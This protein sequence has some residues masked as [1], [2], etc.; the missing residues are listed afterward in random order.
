MRVLIVGGGGR[1]H[2]LAWKISQSDSLSA[3]YA[4]PGNGGIAQLAKCVDIDAEDIDGLVGFAE[5]EKIDFC[6]VGPEAPLF[7]GL[8][9]RL[10][11]EGIAAFGPKQAA[12]A[13]EGSKIFAKDF[14]SRH[15]IPTAPFETFDNR[16]DALAHLAEREAAGRF[17]AVVKADG[18]ALGKGAVVCKTFSDA[19]HAVQD[20]MVARVFGPAGERIVIE[21]C[22]VGR[23]VS[24]IAFVDGK[25]IR[26]MVPAQDHKRAF[27]GD[28]GP[29]TGGMGA[30][31]P[32]P[33]FAPELLDAAKR[34]VLQ[35]TVDGLV[36]DGIEYK[37]ILYAGLM[38]TGDG[39]F[40]LE[41][42]CRFGDPETQ[43]VLPLMSGDLLETMLLCADGRLDR[44]QI[45]WREEKALCVVLASGGY[46]G[47]YDKGFPIE[48]LDAVGDPRVHVFHAG[49]AER[50]GRIVSNGGRVL[51]VTG[52]DVSFEGALRRTYAAVNEIR[53]AKR[54]FRRD[55]GTDAIA[56]L[57]DTG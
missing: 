28:G 21:D 19:E 27:D 54:H 26:P 34:D 36:S 35:R 57:Q 5:R 13:L 30:F 24:L 15:G 40:V 11:D 16:A 41:Y 47:S 56:D 20:M 51:G 52:T 38:V 29:N 37:G 32:V 25:T 12:A 9:D 4:A 8:V 2:A 39:V 22:L 44:A 31:S 43:A 6:V 53:F 1:E 23:E 45:A 46:P 17:P 33:W 7:E 49:T 55:I 48:G 10:S 50:D 18:A 14:M 3:L 42:N